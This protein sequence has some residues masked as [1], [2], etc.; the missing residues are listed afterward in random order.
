MQTDFLSNRLLFASASES[1]AFLM[2]GIKNALT[3]R[4]LKKSLGDQ[5]TW[6]PV[7]LAITYI[8]TLPQP[9][10]AEHLAHPIASSGLNLGPLWAFQF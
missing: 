9:A 3:N 8:Y 5:G 10:V 6:L 4:V 7:R 1:S 2:L